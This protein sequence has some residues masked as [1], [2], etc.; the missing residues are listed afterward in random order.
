MVH[1]METKV[2]RIEIETKEDDKTFYSMRSLYHHSA[3]KYELARCN[4]NT[5]KME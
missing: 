5:Q 3:Y 4:L 1:R 2:C